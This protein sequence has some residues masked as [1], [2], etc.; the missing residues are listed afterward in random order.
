MASHY[1]KILSDALLEVP[2][3]RSDKL[4]KVVDMLKEDHK[5][6][7][8]L[9]GAE[10]YA[11]ARDILRSH[12]FGKAAGNTDKTATTRHA[13]VINS[14]SIPKKTGKSPMRGSIA[15]SAC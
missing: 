9:L 14:S 8:S 11:E 12:T 4:D 5:L 15:P 10:S 7:V 13:S 2:S 3:G 6:C 1:E